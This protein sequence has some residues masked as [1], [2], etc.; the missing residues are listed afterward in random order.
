MPGQYLNTDAKQLIAV[1][2]LLTVSGVA[3]LA[4]VLRVVT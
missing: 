2:L 4:T 1:T 3:V